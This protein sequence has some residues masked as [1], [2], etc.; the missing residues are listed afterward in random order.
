MLK[1]HL[2]AWRVGILALLSPALL[3]LPA[4]HLHPA[5]EHAHGTDGAHK[6]PPVVHADF[7]PVSAHDHGGH[8][9]GHGMPGDTSSGSLSQI[10]FPTLLPR[11]LVLLPPTLEGI[12]VSLPVEAPVA[13]SPFLF[14]TWLLTKDHPPPVQDISFPP[15]SP[16]SPPRFPQ[17][18]RSAVSLSL[19]S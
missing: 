9:R 6:H 15:A 3:L 10:S 7:L 18:K 11:S 12:L 14:H 16:R 2:S 1:R 4:L 17:G 8:H 13:S 19:E 5:Y